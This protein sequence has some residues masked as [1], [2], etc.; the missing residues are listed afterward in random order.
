M[1]Q[2]V[3]LLFGT[4]D[5]GLNLTGTVSF[6]NNV[7]INGISEISIKGLAQW[8]HAPANIVHLNERMIEKFNMPEKSQKL[9]KVGMNWIGIK[10]HSDILISH[11]VR[12]GRNGNTKVQ[13][14]LTK[15][16]KAIGAS[17]VKFEITE[18]TGDAAPDSD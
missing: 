15:F 2:V 13:A 14:Q 11:V 4:D 6:P 12:V 18:A 9:S 5:P 7:N 3:N 8:R 1:P 17:S 16:F 10:A